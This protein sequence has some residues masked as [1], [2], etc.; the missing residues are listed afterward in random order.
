MEIYSTDKIR[1]IIDEHLKNEEN[2][3]KKRKLDDEIISEEIEIKKEQIDIEEEQIEFKNDQKLFECLPTI[4][5]NLQTIKEEAEDYQNSSQSSEYVYVI[6]ELEPANDEKLYLK[7]NDTNKLTKSNTD[8]KKFTNNLSNF[9]KKST[10]VVRTSTGIEIKE[11]KPFESKNHHETLEMHSEEDF[12][13]HV[14]LIQDSVTLNEEKDPSILQSM[15]S[16]VDNSQNYHFLEAH[17]VSQRAYGSDSDPDLDSTTGKYCCNQCDKTFNQ[18]CHLT[19]HKATRHRAN[20]EHKC[21][22]CGKWFKDELTLVKHEMKHNED[23]PWKCKQCPKS[24]CYKADL[25]RHKMIH[26]THKPHICDFC[27]HGFIRHDHLVKHKLTHARKELRRMRNE[28]LNR[29]Q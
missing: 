26:S 4:N 16:N 13:T 29:K 2:P 20:L 25:K 8:Y 23:K 27:G 15:L 19:Q 17:E 6:T 18:K 3:I 28:I 24:F 1:L 10:T 9:A 7:A 21:G 22:K 5:K 14:L 12:P 11:E